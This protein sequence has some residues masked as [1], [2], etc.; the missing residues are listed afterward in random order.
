MRSMERAQKK[1]AEMIAVNAL[2][3]SVFVVLGL[4]IL[5]KGNTPVTAQNTTR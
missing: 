3:A 2:I 5:F 1:V 4:V